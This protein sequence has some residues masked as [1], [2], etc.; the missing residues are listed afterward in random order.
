VKVAAGF[1]WLRIRV[2]GGLLRTSQK[3]LLVPQKCVIYFFVERLFFKKDL[4]LTVSCYFDHRRCIDRILKGSARAFFRLNFIKAPKHVRIQNRIG[5]DEI[6]Y[7]GA[8]WDM[9]GQDMIGWN[10]I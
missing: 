1:I 10:G 9:M 8:R 3:N 6:G 4:Y 7:D 2:S 5:R